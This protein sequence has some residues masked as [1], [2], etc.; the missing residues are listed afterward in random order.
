MFIRH[1]VN[2]TILDEND[3]PPYFPA[4]TPL[5]LEVREDEARGAAIYSAKAFDRDLDNNGLVRYRLDQLDDRD[6]G[7]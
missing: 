1:Q 5:E 2:I 4:T 7:E 6:E 3:N